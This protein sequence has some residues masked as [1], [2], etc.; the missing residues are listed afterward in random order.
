[1][2]VHIS[3]PS[4]LFGFPLLL[5]IMP[6]IRFRVSSGVLITSNF[7]PES[8]GLAVDAVIFHYTH[9]EPLLRYSWLFSKLLA[10]SAVIHH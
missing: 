2:L 9:I 7:E 3:R 4:M 6:N 5:H 8:S 1:M 10:N